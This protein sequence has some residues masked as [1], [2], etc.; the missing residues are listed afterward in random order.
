MNGSLSR[1]RTT[2]PAIRRA[3]RL[4]AVLLQDPGQLVGR[5]GVQHVRG[6][7]SGGAVHAHVERGVLAVGEPALAQVELHG[8]DT[9]VEEHG[10]H[11]VETEV[12]EDRRKLVVDRVHGG[13]PVPERAKTLT[14]ELECRGIPVDADDAGQRAVGE[15]GLGVASETECCVD[16]RGALVLE[17]GHQESDDPVE[18]DRVVVGAAHRVA[19]RPR[20]VRRRNPTASPTDVAAENAITA[21]ASLAWCRTRLAAG[22]STVLL[23]GLDPT[24]VYGWCADVDSSDQVPARSQCGKCGVWNRGRCPRCPGSG[25]ET[26]S[27]ESV[28]ELLLS[29]CVDVLRPA[30]G[31]T[32]GKTSSLCSENAASPASAYSSHR[33]GSQISTR[34]I[35]PITTTSLFSAA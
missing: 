20:L 15:H 13:E 26:S 17:C 25:P 33:A 30:P 9:E 32:P 19:Y 11:P 35:T 29:C 10:V 16:H 21:T 4:L 31:Q 3:N 24:D 18:Q 22:A 28:L 2:A 12:G 27:D 8:G 7:T 5:V 6:G 23:I 1:S 14:G 34:F